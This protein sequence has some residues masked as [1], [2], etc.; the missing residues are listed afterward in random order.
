MAD[1][2]KIVKSASST[3]R[4]SAS[5][6][7]AVAA[8]SENG[9]KKRVTFEVQTKPDSVVFVAGSFNGW[10]NS[11]KCLTDKDGNGLYKCVISLEPGTYE[12]KFCINDTWCVDPAN[13]NF[14]PNDMGT[15]N[16][17]ITVE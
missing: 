10:D 5:K 17:V 12:Y 15:L 16:S 9:S 1:S 3:V 11:K 14:R 2:K 7:T 13:P 4:K 6:S 8:K